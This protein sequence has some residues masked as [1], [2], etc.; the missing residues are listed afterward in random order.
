M[1]REALSLDLDGPT[2]SGPPF[3]LK[4][5]EKFRKH[6]AAIYLPPS[7]VDK[8]PRY[9][10][11]KPL[12]A[13]EFLSFAAHAI[14]FVYPDAK[15]ALLELP[16]VDVYGNTGRSNKK[17][18]VAMTQ[19]TL[20]RGGIWP[21][22]DCVFHKPNDLNISTTISKIAHV[23]WLKDHYDQVSHADDNP[24]NALTMAAYFKDMQ[25][26]IIKDFSTTYLLSGIDLK[27]DFPNV[28]VVSSLRQALESLY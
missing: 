5:V 23:A 6:G 21:R 13:Q 8:L 14:R 28:Q 9:T 1:G 27:R 18:W 17:P 24:E 19:A 12:T 3:Q 2:I 10:S 4:A 7:N 22:L 15:K 20:K 26:R 25:V 11:E 16:N